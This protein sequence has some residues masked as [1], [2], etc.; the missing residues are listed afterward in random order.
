MQAGECVFPVEHRIRILAPQVVF[1]ILPC[2]S[3]AAADHRELQFLPFQFLDHILHLEGRFHQQAAQPD[4]IRAVL[5][6]GTDD[7]VARL[8]DSQVHDL[9][10]VV[11]QNDVDEIFSNVVDIALYRRENDCAF[12]L[13][14]GFLLHL[15]LKI[16]D[17]RLHHSRG[18]EHRGQLHLARSE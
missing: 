17:R 7:H 6:R 3:R 13:R 11:R 1:H 8:L 5:L 9:V 10:S 16:C 4:C 12:L 2:K 18:I 14:A 15:R